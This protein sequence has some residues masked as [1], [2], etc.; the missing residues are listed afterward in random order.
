MFECEFES[1]KERGENSSARFEPSAP[2]AGTNRTTI[3]WS[4]QLVRLRHSKITVCA[5][6][7]MLH[8]AELCD[9]VD[10]P[11]GIVLYDSY[12]YSFYTFTP[13][14]MG[15][16]FCTFLMAFTVFSEYCSSYPVRT[17]S[18]SAHS[19]RLTPSNYMR[20]W[21]S[22]C[23]TSPVSMSMGMSLGQH[24][25]FTPLHPISVCITNFYRAQFVSTS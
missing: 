13:S 3:H 8:C 12:M 15:T 25:E 2:C 18:L 1:I 19:V 24:A 21:P 4:I 5:L 9:T 10:A 20:V 6:G 14:Y 7:M 16:F 22:E 11:D 17:V 23:E